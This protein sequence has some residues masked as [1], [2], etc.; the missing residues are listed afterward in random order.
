[1]IVTDE[2]T[3]R[4][5]VL[6]TAGESLSDTVIDSL[7]ESVVD[8]E[9]LPEQVADVLLDWLSEVVGVIDSVFVDD[10]EDVGEGVTL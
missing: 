6:D 8:H 10:M 9:T 2:D 3:V 5:T 4:V 7:G 1:M